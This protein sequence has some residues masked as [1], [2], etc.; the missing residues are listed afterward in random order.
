MH[1]FCQFVFGNLELIDA[2]SIQWVP[3]KYFFTIVSRS[4]GR[5]MWKRLQEYIGI[6]YVER[7]ISIL[8]HGSVSWSENDW[9]LKTK[10]ISQSFLEQ[11]LSNVP[12]FFVL[13]KSNRGPNIY[14]LG[15]AV[16]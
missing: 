8:I 2:R 10:T 5:L 7:H 4:D 12:L 14:A 9:R 6:A 1:V 3:G 11:N 16:S 15:R 13:L